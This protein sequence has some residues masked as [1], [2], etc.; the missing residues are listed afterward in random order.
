MMKLFVSSR[1]SGVLDQYLQNLIH[2]KQIVGF[3]QHFATFYSSFGQINF[4]L[5]VSAFVIKF[6]KVIF[7][8]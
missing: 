5:L 3:S 6:H 2:L 4:A 7:E 1:Q 8:V